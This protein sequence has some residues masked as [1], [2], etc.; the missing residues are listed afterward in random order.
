MDFQEQAQRHLQV[1][2]ELHEAIASQ[3]RV[4]ARALRAD[5]TCDLGCWLQGEGRRRWPGNHAYLSL[6]EAH[7]DFH[8]AAADVAELINR[9][10]FTEAQRRLRANTPLSVASAALTAGARRM[11]LAVEETVG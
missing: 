1:R 11:R 10:D 5:S 7:R 3:S 4:D 6:L 2:D 9:G 8:A